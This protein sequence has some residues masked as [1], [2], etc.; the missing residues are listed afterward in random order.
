MSTLQ[1][2]DK[3]ISKTISLSGEKLSETLGL[4]ETTAWA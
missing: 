3:R 1:A 2:N 4:R